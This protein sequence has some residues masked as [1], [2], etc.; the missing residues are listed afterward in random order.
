MET[1]NR[2]S[3]VKVILFADLVDSTPLYQ[4][5]GDESAFDLVRESLALMRREIESHRGEL[6]R[7]VGDSVL[8]SFTDSDDAIEAAV[9]IQSVHRQHKLTARVGFHRGEVIPD[10]G[11]VYGSAVNLAARVAG[12]AKGGEICATHPAIEALSNRYRRSAVLIDRINLKGMSQP[13]RIYRYQ[14]ADAEPATV[15]HASSA[16][17]LRSAREPTLELLIDER[18]RLHRAD[19]GCFTIGRADDSSLML[20]HDASS[21]HHASIEY[22]RGRYVIRDTSTNG[23]CIQ[24]AERPLIHLRREEMALEGAGEIGFGWV[25]GEVGAPRIHYRVSKDDVPL[26]G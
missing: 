16:A 13:H 1:V 20:A 14:W 21:R 22:I 24:I 18:S 6:L 23:T 12:F 3:E 8:A 17:M 4:R 10:Q 15:V 9:G 2:R 5:E 7:T 26:F 19:G 25:P 11:D